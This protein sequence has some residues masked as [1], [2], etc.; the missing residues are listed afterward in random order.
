[1]SENSPKPAENAPEHAPI[2]ALSLRAL[3]IY[4]TF[5]LWGFGTG[6]QQLAR[7]LAPGSRPR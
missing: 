3:P 2:D 5:F 7:L 1:M 6:A 4:S